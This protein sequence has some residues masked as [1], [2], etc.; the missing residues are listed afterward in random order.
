MLLYS[1]DK[2]ILIN[3]FRKDKILQ[4]TNYKGEKRR[5][6]LKKQKKKEDKLKLK[7]EK[8]NNPIPE[9]SSE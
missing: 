8:A 3:G 5:K 4:K 9:E 7:Q 2:I 1:L 6:E